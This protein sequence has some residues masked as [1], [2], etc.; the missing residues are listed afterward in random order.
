M[1]DIGAITN[2]LQLGENGIWY[3]EVCPDISYPTDGNENCYA[4]EDDS[5]WFRHRNQCIACVVSLFPPE[6]GKTVFD[7]GGGNGKVSMG[8]GEAGFDP[9]L[10]EPGVI[11]ASNAKKR[12]IEQVI[13]S[14][15]ETAKFR[16]GSLPAVGLFDVIEHIENDIAFL[17]SVRPLLKKGGRLYAT[18]PA[19][20]ALWSAEDVNAG[21]FRRYD[22]TGF[23]KV[24]EKAGFEIEYGSYI[25]RLL[26]IPIFFLR[27]LPFRLGL[28]G[29]RKGQVNVQRDHAVKGGLLTRVL[30]NFLHSEI[31]LLKRKK[32]M[33]FGGSCLVVARVSKEMELQ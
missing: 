12:G 29:R 32:V 13:C 5:F 27:A 16:K 21:H 33:R 15:V 23:G 3:S 28:G 6:D 9:V 1:V 20:G 19:F 8:L 10:V 4:I 26:P 31:A 11:G 18:V 25:F 7:L 14:T 22:L 30:N 17:Q 2:G 24:L